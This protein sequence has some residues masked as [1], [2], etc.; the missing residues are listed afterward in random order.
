MAAQIRIKKPLKIWMCTILL[1][2]TFQ[3]LTKCKANKTGMKANKE[4]KKLIWMTG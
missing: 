1:I 3:P 2:I 4:I